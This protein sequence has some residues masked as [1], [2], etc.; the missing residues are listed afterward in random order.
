MFEARLR[1]VGD[2]IALS[3]VISEADFI[4]TRFY[5]DCLKPFRQRDGMGV[6]GLRSGKRIAFIATT[7]TDDCP[8]F[9]PSDKAALKILAPHVTRTLKISD[10]LELSTLKSLA[11]ETTLDQLSAGVILLGRHGRVVHMNR[12]AETMAR[13]GRSI[14]IANHR[15]APVDRHAAASLAK[16]LD[17]CLNKREEAQNGPISIGL[18]EHDG[19]GLIASILN[20]QSGRR[21]DIV[22]PFAAVTAVFLQELRT[23]APVP[24]DAFARLYKLTTGELRVALALAPGLGIREASELLGISEA[25]VKTHLQRVFAKTAT[26]RQTELVQLL[27]ASKPVLTEPST[28]H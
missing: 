25:T 24:G 3:D 20:L 23:S 27:Q 4:R 19:P 12:S 18:P 26:T 2:V 16:G 11:L 15:I 6:L 22:E 14:R 9:T 21:H 1:P 10:A 7:R 5:R 8:R 17:A 28:S 13:Q